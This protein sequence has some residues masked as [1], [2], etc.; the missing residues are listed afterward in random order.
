MAKAIIK[1]SNQM[2]K[3]FGIK[4]F[5]SN[6]IDFELTINSLTQIER[7]EYTQLIRSYSS[8]C[9]C[10]SGK[11]SALLIGLLGVICH[12]FFLKFPTNNLLLNLLICMFLGAII[13]KVTSLVKSSLKI[14][15]ITLK[16]E[17]IEKST[18]PLN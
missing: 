16:I 13:G 14:K 6:S 4:S 10:E 17:K 18:H 9:G 5:F 3:V 12:L 8:N 2:R 1:N 11:I 15:E 7:Q